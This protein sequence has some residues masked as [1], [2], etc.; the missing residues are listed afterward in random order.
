MR[1]ANANTSYRIYYITLAKSSPYYYDLA[2]SK[3]GIYR[4][5]IDTKVSR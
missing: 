1:Y 4:L 5:L 3:A 2:I